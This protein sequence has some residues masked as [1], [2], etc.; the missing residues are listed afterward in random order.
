MKKKSKPSWAKRSRGQNCPDKR[1]TQTALVQRASAAERG[2]NSLRRFQSSSVRGH[3]FDSL[4]GPFPGGPTNTW[5]SQRETDRALS[6]VTSSTLLH[7]IV[8]KLLRFGCGV[9]VPPTA[10]R[11]HKE[12]QHRS[13]RHLKK[14][15]NNWIVWTGQW[16]A[17]LMR[18][19][20]PNNLP[21]V[22]VWASKVRE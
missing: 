16:L 5:P 15:K 3:A 19:Y 22:F 2:G 11:L 21:R 10:F 6:P 20:P 4:S 12:L 14:L 17:K 1:H 9:R 18:N 8:S 13:P 7:T